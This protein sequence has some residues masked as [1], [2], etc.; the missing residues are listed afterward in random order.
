M[1]FVETPIFT[2]DIDMFLLP[3]QYRALQ[4]AL[5]LRPDAGG[6]IP[7]S[8]GIRKLRWGLSGTGKR[9]GLRILYFWEVSGETLYLLAVFRKNRQEDL[10]ASQLAILRRLVSEGL[11]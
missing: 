8:G 11:S 9:G 5:L 6:I 7:G 10:T 4:Q 1:K 2:H 3:E